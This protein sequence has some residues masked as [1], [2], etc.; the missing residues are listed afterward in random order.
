MSHTVAVNT[1]YPEELH[2]ALHVHG[3]WPTR[4]SSCCLSLECAAEFF[5]SRPPVFTTPKEEVYQILP[6]LSSKGKGLPET[7][8]R[9]ERRSCFGDSFSLC[10]Q[11]SQKTYTYC[12]RPVQICPVPFLHRLLMGSVGTAAAGIGQIQL[13]CGCRPIERSFRAFFPGSRCGKQGALQLRQNHGAPTYEGS[14][15]IYLS[16]PT[17]VIRNL[18]KKREREREIT[19]ALKTAPLQ[20]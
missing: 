2:V 19:H 9:E 1:R 3:E 18:D 13:T 16:K 7:M 10:F 15:K 5:E 11:G 8:E 4:R 17:I 12:F 6:G 14:V 20:R